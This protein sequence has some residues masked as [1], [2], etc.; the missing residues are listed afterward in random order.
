VQENSPRL[1]ENAQVHGSGV[2]IDPAVK[3]VLPLVETH[4]S[5]LWDG[6]GACASKPWCEVPLHLPRWDK[7][8]SLSPFTKWDRPGPSQVRT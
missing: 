7:A 3:S 5:L 4:H 8:W 1:I 6:T 2:K